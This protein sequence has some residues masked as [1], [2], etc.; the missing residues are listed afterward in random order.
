MPSTLSFVHPLT[1][2]PLTAIAGGWQLDSTG[3]VF[4]NQGSVPSFVPVSLRGHVEE[5]RSDFVNMVKTLLRSWPKLYVALIWLI[6]PVC[7]T[8][9]TARKFLKTFA[10]D[11]LL[12]N[13][14]SG[15]HQ[16]GER[17]INTDIFPYKGVDVVAD[18]TMLPFADNTFDGA[19]CEC[20]LEHVTEPHKVVDEML[21]VLKPGGRIFLS[22]PFVYPF[23]ACP[24]DY[25]RW[26]SM[27]VRELCK[28]GHIDIVAS[29]SG[30]TSAL[31]AQ[32]VTWLAITLSFGS[33]KLY[34]VLSMVLLIPLSPLKFFDYIVGRFPTA[35]HGTEAFY[36]VVSK[37][38]G[39]SG[40]IAV[41]NAD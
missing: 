17:V 20:L 9:L 33:T 23:H 8:G 24:H 34:N 4:A 13:V 26:S 36:A 37:R 28:N 41:Q 18:A 19:I 6:S 3:E 5:E 1:R 29:R 30:P 40:Q 12:L 25:Y 32:L 11:A 39:Q 21:R 10:K 35:I 7:Y 15:V 27:G 14:G 16:F 2:Q 22:V 38:T 31:V